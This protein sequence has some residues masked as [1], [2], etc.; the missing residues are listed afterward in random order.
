MNA[1]GISGLTIATLSSPYCT[2]LVAMHNTK[3]IANTNVNNSTSA[4][5][6]ISTAIQKNAIAESIAKAK[7][8]NS[9]GMTLIQVLWRYDKP[10]VKRQGTLLPILQSHL[11]ILRNSD[12]FYKL[13]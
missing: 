4:A 7:H 3:D 12:D 9:A 10:V 5:L 8:S 6:T 1:R 13:Y 2:S 11:V